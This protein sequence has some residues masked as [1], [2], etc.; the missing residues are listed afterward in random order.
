[1]S[2]GPEALLTWDRVHALSL[3]AM[4]FWANY[5]RHGLN[6]SPQ[7]SYVEVLVTSVMVFGGGAFES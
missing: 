4:Y 7:N 5:Y 3:S 6:M 1:M 2:L